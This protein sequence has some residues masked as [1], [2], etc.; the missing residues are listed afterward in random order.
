VMTDA[1]AIPLRVPRDRNGE[2][3]PQLVPKHQ[4]RLAGFNDL[5]C[6]LMSRGMS[7]RDICDQMNETYGVAMSP[8]LVSKIT[9]AVMPEVRA[10]LTR[11]LDACYPIM[12]M[13]AIV[14][15]VRTDGRV[16]RPG[17]P[18]GSMSLKQG[19]S[20]A[21]RIITGE[22]DDSSLQRCGEGRR[23][24]SGPPVA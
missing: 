6:G 8:E 21:E 19:W 1:G 14:V 5:I 24:A 22:A 2:F 12:Y 17:Y 23:G 9:D 7:T 10:W 16:N 13:D 3:D 20:Y 4:R 18:G 11:P 15:K